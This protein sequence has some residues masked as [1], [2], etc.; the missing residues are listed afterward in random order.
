MSSLIMVGNDSDKATDKEYFDLLSQ[1]GLTVPSR[2]M[3]EFVCA[4][5]CYTWICRS[6]YGKKI[7]NPPQEFLQDKFWEYIL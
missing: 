3:A 6:V 1:E 7:M 4:C 5:F 2:Q